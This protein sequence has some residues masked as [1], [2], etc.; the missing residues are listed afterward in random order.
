MKKAFVLCSLIGMLYTGTAIAQTSGEKQLQPKTVENAPQ[1]GAGAKLI[2]FAKT[3]IGIPYRY[4]S[5]NPNIGFDCSGFVS[6][7]FKN[8]GFSVPRS[9]PEFV[10]AGKPVK[11]ENAKVGD[12]LIFTGSNPKNRKIGHVGIVYKIDGDEIE[13]IHSSSGKAKGVTI[14]TMDTYYK[15]RF[16]KAVSVL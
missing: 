16:M 9:S 7:V 4:A 10:A 14:T 2:S 6:Y 11:L 1:E 13:F 8:F 3:M 15:R 5:S 12:I